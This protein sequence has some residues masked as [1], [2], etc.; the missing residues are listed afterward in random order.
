MKNKA[1]IDSNEPDDVKQKVRKQLEKRGFTVKTKSLDQG[2][3]LYP[4]QSVVVERKEKSDLAKSIQ[5]RRISKQADRMAANHD[6]LYLVTE[7][8][9][10]DLEHTNLHHNSIRGQ[11]I[12]LAVKRGL[13]IIP[14]ENKDGTAYTIARLFERYKDEE[15]KQNT[16]Y[17]KTHD[18]GEVENTQA[19]MLMQ[20][21][22]ISQNKAEQILNEISFQELA[23]CAVDIG[24]EGPDIAKQAIQSIDGIGEI[25]AERVVKSFQ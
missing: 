16:E 8:D 7:G 19:A 9:V 11:L 5:D 15:H 17:L 13:N 20:I 24:Y 2:D 6:H 23:D 25:L 12:S 1:I 3:F 22:G 21:E 4:H 10:Y 14:T 18:T